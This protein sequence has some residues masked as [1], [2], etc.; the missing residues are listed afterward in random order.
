[1]STRPPPN[2]HDGAVTEVNAVGVPRPSRPHLPGVRPSGVGCG[3][4]A[5]S[6]DVA[7]ERLFASHDYWVAT[8]EATGDRT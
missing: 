7:R 2:V 5:A 4:R 1:M 6:V 3:D 8:S